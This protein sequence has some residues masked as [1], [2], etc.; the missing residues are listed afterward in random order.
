MSKTVFGV[1]VGGALGLL[2]G[3]SAWMS[4]EARPMM[5]M[6]VVGS[7]I[8]GVLT[9]AAA[10][11]AAR[12]WGSMLLAV[13]VG[14]V[15]GFVLSTVVALGQPG[16]YWEIVLPGMLVGFLSGFMTQRYARGSQARRAGPLA[17]VIL[18]GLVALPVVFASTQT[19]T[20][21]DPL[22]SL[23]PLIGRWEGTSEGVPGKSSVQREYTRILGTRFIHGRNRSVYAPQ[24]KNPKG[25]THEDIGIFSFDTARQRIVLRQF[26][27][28]GFVNQYVQDAESNGALVFTTEAIENIPAGWRARE[29]YRFLSA[30]EFEEVFELA[31][32]G[33][34][35]AVYSRSRLRK[36]R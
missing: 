15:V 25:E 10:G 11:F 4:P 21:A 18:V 6:I 29:T 33:K 34:D 8:K 22:A 28:E 30:D 32:S 36:V 12:R 7:T 2:D 20:P 1:L 23:E 3:L 19:R 31:Q 5:A 35:F 16:H 14:L 24:E 26:H 27:V 9:G 13:G 17:P